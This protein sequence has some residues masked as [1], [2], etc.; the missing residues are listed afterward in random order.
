MNGGAAS[1]A[2]QSIEVTLNGF[3]DGNQQAGSV[4]KAK[5]N[6]PQSTTP[7]VTQAERINRDNFVLFRIPD[8]WLVA[9]DNASNKRL[10]LEARAR[11]PVG[12]GSG[13]LSECP[14]ILILIAGAGCGGDNTFRV[15]GV[16]VYRDLQNLTIRTLP[17]TKPTQTA[18]TFPLPRTVLSR[19][20]KLFPGGEGLNILP[21]DAELDI[22]PEALTMASAACQHGQGPALVQVG[23]RRHRSR[24]V[25]GARHAD[26]EGYGML[27]G[28]HRYSADGTHDEP[29]WY[30]GGTPAPK[31]V[32]TILVNDGSRNGL[33]P[34]PRTSTSTRGGRLTP[35]PAPCRARPLL[36]AAR[37]VAAP[38]PGRPTTSASSRA[39][40]SKPACVLAP[41]R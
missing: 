28:V 36:A 24:R 33:S 8:A 38:S 37:R 9:A 10:D 35:T 29:G 2:A 12:A 41:H 11:L 17:L 14:L 32:P 18:A 39:S 26:S 1:D 27:M 6:P 40:R 5:P 7:W 20:R 30:Q 34:R 16:P 25:E 23:E 21:Y 13:T 19:T 22:D 4:T 31:G 15:D 3:V